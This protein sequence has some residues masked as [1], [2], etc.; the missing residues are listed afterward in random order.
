MKDNW[1][2]KLIVAAVLFVAIIVIGF[3]TMHTPALKY[4]L[5]EQQTL[6]AIA[7][8][9]EQISPEKAKDIQ[10]A[11][12][13]AFVFVDLRNENE[14]AKGHHEGALNIPL[15]KL[16]AEESLEFIKQAATENKML[17]LYGAD[18]SQ[19]TAPWLLLK[20]M[21]FGNVCVL[22]GGYTGLTQSLTAAADSLPRQSFD[23][24]A[25]RY[26][27]A[28]LGQGQPKTAAATASKTAPQQVVT[29]P[30]PK[31]KA[32]TAGGC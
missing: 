16:L 32:A 22:Q 2:N 30:K 25:P 8:S 19:V 28:E 6:A 21:G 13:P 15:S 23:A 20:Q 1:L 3:L 4:E 9:S 14:F 12:N 18:Q 7:A 11:K 24:E 29:K 10:L 5:T 31:S 26:K 17:I 27:F